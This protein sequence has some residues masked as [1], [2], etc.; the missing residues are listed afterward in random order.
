MARTD[1]QVNFRIPTE[2]N[3]LLKDAAARNGRTITAELVWRLEKS[4]LPDGGKNEDL[5]LRMKLA[6][7]RELWMS[8]VELLAG[9]HERLVAKKATGATV[10]DEA[11][12]NRPIDEAIERVHEAMSYFTSQRDRATALLA[13][14]AYAEAMKKPMPAEMIRAALADRFINLPLDD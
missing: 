1:P 8:T 11:E 14:I 5:N 12:G 10:D 4:F 3:D 6:A 9:R 13:E 2:L 7:H